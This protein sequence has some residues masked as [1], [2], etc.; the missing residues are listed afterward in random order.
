MH[1]YIYKT[2]VGQTHTKIYLRNRR[3]GMLDPAMDEK[4]S[5]R[6]FMVAEQDRVV[7]EGLEPRI[8]PTSAVREV[9]VPAGKVIVRYRERLMEWQQ[10]GWRIDVD[11]VESRGEDVAFAIPSPARREH[12][13]WAL[14]P[15]PLLAAE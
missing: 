4:V 1:Q 11:A 8:T 5:Q 10:R 12:K 6:N 15:I 9:L 14:R 13:R 2:P 7:M 3:N